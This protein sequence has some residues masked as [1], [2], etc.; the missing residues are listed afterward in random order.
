MGNRL[1]LVGFAVVIEYLLSVHPSCDNTTLRLEWIFCRAGWW[2]GRSCMHDCVKSVCPSI[3]EVWNKF[4]PYCVGKLIHCVLVH[5][6][7]LDR[8]HHLDLSFGSLIPS[9]SMSKKRSE[10]CICSENFY[11]THHAMDNP[12]IMVIITGPQKLIRSNGN[13]WVR[14]QNMHPPC[15]QDCTQQPHSQ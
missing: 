6:S 9:R 7:C 15:I 5:Y 8:K 14:C 13:D 12:K 2:V 4:H 10:I 1:C 3:D 11:S